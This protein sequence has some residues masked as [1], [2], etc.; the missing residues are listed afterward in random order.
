MFG[1]L[2]VPVCK[3]SVPVTVISF[4]MSMSLT[5]ASFVIIVLVEISVATKLV[6]STLSNVIDP[7]VNVPVVI[8]DTFKSN[9][10]AMVPRA[11][12]KANT[13][14]T[15][16]KLPSGYCIINC[17]VF[18]VCKSSVRLLPDISVVHCWFIFGY[19]PNGQSMP[20]Y[21]FQE[22]QR[23]PCTNND[24][25]SQNRHPSRSLSQKYKAEHIRS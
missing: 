23:Q 7:A 1:A 9:D 20:V 14:F 22:F 17:F 6:T 15:G 24:H 19:W 25:R 4:A 12:E 10:G 2:I 21:L 5:V 3:L 18:S 11:S 16:A 13:E 8:D